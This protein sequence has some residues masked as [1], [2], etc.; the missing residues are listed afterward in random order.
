MKSARLQLL[1]W[2]IIVYHR[3][4]FRAAD[5]EG[6]PELKSLLDGPISLLVPTIANATGTPFAEYSILVPFPFWQMIKTR[7]RSIEPHSKE[8][9]PQARIWYVVRD[10]IADEID[11]QLAL[12]ET[13]AEGLKNDN[14]KQQTTPPP[15]TPP[16]GQGAQAS[17][18]CHI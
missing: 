4:L 10:T 15:S 13:S 8:S 7:F 9:Q 17:M 12:P 1:G 14:K 3:L 18:T 11:R 2:Q 16:D 5:S 6:N